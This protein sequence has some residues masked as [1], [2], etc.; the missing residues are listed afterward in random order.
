MAGHPLATLA[1]F[2]RRHVVHVAERE[3]RAWAWTAGQAEES[4]KRGVL[5]QE[6]AFGV[7]LFGEKRTGSASKEQTGVRATAGGRGVRGDG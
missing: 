6:A 2:P 3:W 4:I 7:G 5:P 1:S